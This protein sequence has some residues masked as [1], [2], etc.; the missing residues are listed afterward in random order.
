MMQR[1]FT[2]METLVAMVIFSFASMALL[3]LYSGS[4]RAQAAHDSLIERSARGESLLLEIDLNRTF[5]AS[6]SGT[7]ADGAAWTIA[8]VQ[9]AP[10][11][12]RI[13]IEV[14]DRAGRTAHLQTH[15]LPR[16]LGMEQ[17]Q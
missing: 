7:D 12:V 2:L 3:D 14:R 9:V 4:A 13:D 5:E 10:N 16:E 6:R 1:G 8:M 15:R 17:V 11:L